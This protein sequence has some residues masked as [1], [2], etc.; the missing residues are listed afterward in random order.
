MSRKE[1]YSRGAENG[2]ARRDRHRCHMKHLRRTSLFTVHSPQDV[3]YWKGIWQ[4]FVL[5]HPQ[6]REFIVGLVYIVVFHVTK[7]IKR[8]KV[9]EDIYSPNFVKTIPCET[10]E[11]LI[12]VKLALVLGLG[13]SWGIS[14]WHFPKPQSNLTIESSKQRNAI[15]CLKEWPDNEEWVMIIF[16]L[17]NHTEMNKHKAGIWSINLALIFEKPWE[18]F[19]Q[20]IGIVQ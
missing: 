6:Y 20:L 17:H 3:Y 5:R 18:F 4:T 19:S 16:S 12:Y 10:V 14:S 11:H 2:R 8:S 1:I 15:L 7:T 9:L 13:F